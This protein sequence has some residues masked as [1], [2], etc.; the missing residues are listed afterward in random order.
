MLDIAA[1]PC[2]PSEAERAVAPSTTSWSPS[3]ILRMGEEKLPQS[4]SFWLRYVY[5]NDTRRAVSLR[6]AAAA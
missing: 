5:S 3:P 6:L 2:Q 1:A 4:I